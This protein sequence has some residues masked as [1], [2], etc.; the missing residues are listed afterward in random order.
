M[1]SVLCWKEGSLTSQHVSLD[2]CLFFSLSPAITHSLPT[3]PLFSFLQHQVSTK[4]SVKYC[5]TFHLLLIWQIDFLCV[6]QSLKRGFFPHWGPGNDLAGVTNNYLPVKSRKHFSILIVFDLLERVTLLATPSFSASCG[7]FPWTDSLPVDLL[8][9]W[10]LLYRTPF[11]CP[12]MLMFSR[13]SVLCS[14]FTLTSPCTDYIHISG[15]TLKVVDFQIVIPSHVTPP[16][17]QLRPSHAH[18][19]ILQTS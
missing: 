5:L 9:P 7:L 6:P 14:L 15:F 13:I 2:R 16:E 8:C 17:F 12:Q 4:S 19:N 11:L 1:S 10:L 18:L 3:P